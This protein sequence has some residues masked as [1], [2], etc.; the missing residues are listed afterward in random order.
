MV[1]VAQVNLALWRVLVIDKWRRADA[2]RQT[3]T[4]RYKIIRLNGKRERSGVAR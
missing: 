4:R 3:S 2:H 1:N